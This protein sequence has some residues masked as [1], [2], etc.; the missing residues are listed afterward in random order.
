M[1]KL[2]FAQRYREDRRFKD[3]IE[4]LK[5]DAILRLLGLEPEELVRHWELHQSLPSLDESQGSETPAKQEEDASPV[6][7]LN[8]REAREQIA[9]LEDA[10]L[11]AA[12]IETDN[13]KTVREAARSALASL[14]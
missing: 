11:L 14:I 10:E 9:D 12:I 2:T 3:A 8:V 5:R 13:R 1:A 4:D 6:A 7:D